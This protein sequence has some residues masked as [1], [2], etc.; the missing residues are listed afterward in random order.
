MS[1]ERKHEERIE[2]RPELTGLFD[3]VRNRFPAEEL[4]PRLGQE[5]VAELVGR[6]G[7]ERW[8]QDTFR[9]AKPS[10]GGVFSVE[11]SKTAVLEF[12]AT[13]RSTSGSSTSHGQS[14]SGRT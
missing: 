11:D 1:Y 9:G 14:I 6:I 7:K 4:L 13:S 12:A 3:V 5:L 2:G 10:P 8:H